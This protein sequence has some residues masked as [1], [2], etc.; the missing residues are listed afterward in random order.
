[1]ATSNGNS[2]GIKSVESD[3]VEHIALWD[4]IDERILVGA[5]LKA[6][7]SYPEGTVIYAGT[8]I[9]VK[10]GKLGGEAELNSTTPVGLTEVDVVM[11]SEFATF[12]IVK[13]GIIYADR[14]K[15]TISDEQ[16]KALPGITFVKEL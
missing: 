13:R 1:M 8:P 7:G 4:R 16:K 15:A 11:G 12:T 2:F 6:G 10:D 3:V 14:T 5:T 9:A